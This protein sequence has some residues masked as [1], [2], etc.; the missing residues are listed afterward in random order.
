VR[1]SKIETQKRH[2]D[3]VSVFIDGEFRFGLSKVL[4]LKHDLAEDREITEEEITTVLYQE[5]KEKIRERA[6]R[7]LGFRDRSVQEMRERLLRLGFD[8]ARI[9]ETIAELVADQTLDDRRFSRAFTDDYTNLKPKGNQYLRRELKHK[10]VA[11]EI[12]EEVTAGRDEKAM[13]RRL[14]A[15]KLRSLD[16]RD[17]KQRQKIVRYLAYRGF[18]LSAILD[19]LEG[20]DE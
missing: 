7:L 8:A 6:F 9:E 12:I 13:I 15:D 2:K 11:D 18:S 10:K 4:A 5:E 1:I 14:L 17:P 20:R 19:V 16:R 3:R